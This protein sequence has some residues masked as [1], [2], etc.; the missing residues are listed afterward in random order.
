MLEPSIEQPTVACAA[1]TPP[2]PP[3]LAEILVPLR[4]VDTGTTLSKEMFEVRKV[5][6]E[7]IPPGVVSSPHDVEGRIANRTLPKGQLIFPRDLILEMSDLQFDIPAGSRAVTIDVN[8]TT[9]VEGYTRPGS[10]VDINFI[11]RDEKGDSAVTTLVHNAKV[12]SV[13]GGTTRDELPPAIGHYPLTVVVSERDAKSIQLASASGTLSLSLLAT[14][15]QTVA[16]PTRDSFT[17]QTLLDTPEDGKDEPMF[18]PLPVVVQ[19]EN[20]SHLLITNR[21]SAMH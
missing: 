16:D 5:L 12:V 1:Q 2:P 18:T 10:T 17:L 6:A 3:P 9:S 19:K 14:A 11:Y 7:F 21:L 8:S 13:N 4:D 20:D 15:E